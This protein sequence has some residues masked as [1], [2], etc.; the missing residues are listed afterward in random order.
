MPKLQPVDTQ[1]FSL[2]EGG[3]GFFS[4]EDRYTRGLDWYRSHFKFPPSSSQF[5]LRMVDGSRSSFAAPFAAARMRAVLARP[6]MH[7]II[8]VL[9]DPAQLAWV[10]WRE[11]NAL[12]TRDESSSLGSLLAPYLY[13]RNFSAKAELEATAL[14]RCLRRAKREGGRS[15]D[16][17]GVDRGGTSG[18]GRESTSSITSETWQRCIAVGCGWSSCVVGAGLYAPQL[19]TWRV[20]YQPNQIA[21]FTL[22]ELASSTRQAMSRL[23]AFVGMPVQE[24]TSAYR[25]AVSHIAARTSAAVAAGQAVPSQSYATLS[26]FYARFA[27]GVR[28]EL[29][30]MMQPK[31][32]VDQEPWLW[33]DLD[34]TDGGAWGGSNAG[35]SGGRLGAR[36]DTV[37]ERGDPRRSDDT[38]NADLRHSDLPTVFLLGGEKCGS[39]SL[40]FAL[41]RHPQI[42]MARHALPG[43]PAFF[44]KELHFFDDDLRYTRGLSFYAAH[45]PR[46]TRGALRDEASGAAYLGAGDREESAGRQ[47]ARGDTDGTRTRG[48]ATGRAGR[49]RSA[50]TSSRLSS[51]RRYWHHLPTSTSEV[52]LEDAATGEVVGWD[53]ELNIPGDVA[54]TMMLIP[55]TNGSSSSSSSSDD[56]DAAA[57]ASGSAPARRGTRGHRSF[58]LVDSASSQLLYNRDWVLRAAPLHG[59]PLPSR[60]VAFIPV[61]PEKL[62]PDAAAGTANGVGSAG[63]QAAGGAPAFWMVDQSTN[64]MLYWR[65]DVVRVRPFTRD[66]SSSWRLRRLSDDSCPHWA[67]VEHRHSTVDGT[68]ESDG[69]WALRIA[70]VARGEC[71]RGCARGPLVRS[72]AALVAGES[73]LT[74][75]RRNAACRATC[76]LDPLFAA[77]GEGEQAGGRLARPI[78]VAPASAA[79]CL[80]GS[81]AR[82]VGNLVVHSESAVLPDCGCR[83]G[84]GER[85]MLGMD[86]TPMMH[87]L[88]AAWRMAKALPTPSALRFVIIFREPAERAA[89]HY[90][91]MR[92]LAL[93][94]EAWAA[95]YVR[96]A[97]ASADERLLA[98]ASAF[99]RCVGARIHA[100]G[101]P[102]GRLPPKLWHECIAVACGFHAC[103]VGQSIY[104]PQLRAWLN[105]FS[106]PQFAV[107]TLDEF[108]RKPS[109][110][111]GRIA[112]FLGVVSFPRLVLNWKWN[113]NVGKQSS[114][115]DR[116]QV[117]SDATLAQLRHFFAP[118]TDAL[119]VL[120]RKR[121]QVR[122]AVSVATWPRS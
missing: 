109:A 98:E 113:W 57:A 21:V 43:E 122:A 68:H 58:W 62:V 104:E 52:L 115:K 99:S 49:R 106:S 88:P 119:G 1:F 51:D 23:L 2:R 10:L 42:Q 7:R 27:P 50:G 37:S 4:A 46:C 59:P 14:A 13:P 45:F 78:A 25:R 94:G 53:A 44:R 33:A 47:H 120:L 85:A 114:R 24:S 97:N 11:L 65:D 39:T 41:S 89:S 79:G 56:D 20:A 81:A 77:D 118:Y 95:L 76:A 107:L 69:E 71:S 28:H 74:S 73:A 86:A 66:G 29:A 63:D 92:K 101:V 91:M 34:G 111:L 117:V 60:G 93:R 110:A 116:R 17:R 48:A 16:E 121:G 54:R 112:T 36:A 87:R 9:R 32:S 102:S 72:L 103:V 22:A 90:G 19:R 108:A 80:C 83:G 40:A 96:R 35:S 18:T 26:R 8:I 100:R 30:L 38:A 15:G 67:A 12:P 31:R 3:P 61:P 105:T 70:T 75:A 5:G 82:R 6:S 64:R 55:Y 84:A